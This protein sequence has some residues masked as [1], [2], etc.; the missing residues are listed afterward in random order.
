MA[1]RTARPISSGST[2]A[3]F[4]EYARY[5]AQDHDMRPSSLRNYLSDL[6]LFMDWYKCG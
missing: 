2:L 4:D 3:N 5:L 6:R 1:K